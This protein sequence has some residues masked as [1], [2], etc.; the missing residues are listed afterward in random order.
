MNLL[1]ISLDKLISILGTDTALGLTGEQVLR[2]RREFGENVARENPRTVS[3][4]VRKIFGDVMMI[5]FLFTGL[6]DYFNSHN[7]VSLIC[8]LFAAVLYA[9]LVFGSFLYVRRVD[10]A[11]EKFS[12]NRVHVRRNGRII[13]VKNRDLVPGDIL[14]LER[15]DVLPCDGIILSAKTLLVLE[16]KSAGARAPAIKRSHTEVSD[17][18]DS[19]YF[20]CVLFAGSVVLQ[21]AAHVFVCNTGADLFD[22]ENPTVSRQIGTV[23]R[24]YRLAMSLKKEILLIW[25]LACFVIFAWGV[26]RGQDVFRIFYYSAAMV[27]AAFPSSIEYYCDLAVAYMKSRLFRAGAIL[28]NPGAVDRLCDA[29]RI[30]IHSADY[31]YYAKPL[32]SIYYVGDREYDFRQDH[33]PAKPMLE[34]LL[35]ASM[36]PTYWNDPRH[37]QERKNE[38]VIQGAAARCGLQKRRLDHDY[39]FVNHSDPDE[40][41]AYSCSLVLRDGAYRLV[42]RGDPKA[43]LSLCAFY[44]SGP[45]DLALTDGVSMLIR[46]TFRRIAGN[47]E[48]IVAVAELNLPSPPEGDLRRVCRKMSYMGVFGLSTPVSASAAEEVNSCEKAG[49]NTYL[50]TDDYPETVEALAKS[51]SIIKEK[52]DQHALRYDSYRRMDRGVFVADLER[53]KAFSQF[54]PEEKQIILR[55]HK[56]NG[57]KTLS[58]TDGMRDIL[59]QMESDISFADAAESSPAVRMNAD[60]L[61]RDK[62]YNLVPLSIHWSRLLYHNLVHIMQFILILQVSLF[63]SVFLCLTLTGETVYPLFPMIFAGLGAA[64]PCTFNIYHR[65]PG[66]VL[67]RRLG[68]LKDRIYSLQVLILI[69]A[70][71]GLVGAIGMT[72]SRQITLFSS[73]SADAACGAGILTMAFSAWFASLSIKTE[74]PLFRN[75][76]EIGRTG[77]ITFLITLFVSVVTVFTPF[78]KL[79]NPSYEEK[80]AGLTFATGALS[81]LLSLL[82]MLVIELMKYL[83]REEVPSGQRKFSR[84]RIIAVFGKLVKKRIPRPDKAKGVPEE[85]P[86]PLEISKKEASEQAGEEQAEEEKAEDQAPEDENE[87][88][89]VLKDLKEILEKIEQEKTEQTK[90]EFDEEEQTDEEQSEENERK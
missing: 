38:R 42:V 85:A 68:V 7:V 52:D 57:H 61:M 27:I 81:L 16:A 60:V 33:I 76:R 5:I 12:K 14:I 82:P 71:A 13:S 11:V 23:P 8:I 89:T 35:L 45:E 41:H 87:E 53:Y 67:P 26:F 63:F 6:F 29:D 51:V 59:P 34:D 32:A 83:R 18:E 39:L 47:C 40:Q 48:H 9:A 46:S 30:F 55:Y 73:G 19:E 3:S 64:L 79:Y 74:G 4:L 62:K 75:L 84:S 80:G 24:V 54:P 78:A 58:L 15:G 86:A 2:N 21:G 1:E 10:A 20:D 56:N 37:A 22:A 28:R 44:R 69:P 17:L 72:L 77:L 50:L 49:I 70:I 90:A 88:D 66:A 31:L 36:S 25:V 65:K 43:V